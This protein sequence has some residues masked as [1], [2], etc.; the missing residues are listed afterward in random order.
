MPMHQRAVEP[1]SVLPRFSVALMVIPAIAIVEHKYGSGPKQ[2]IRFFCLTQ[3]HWLE[4][5]TR[6]ELAFPSTPAASHT[7]RSLIARTHSLAA[8]PPS[9]V[10]KENAKSPKGSE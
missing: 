1:A 5:E 4:H 7:R 8:A 9:S 3:S 2:T 6:F 10:G